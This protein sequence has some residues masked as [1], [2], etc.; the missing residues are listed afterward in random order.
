M[1]VCGLHFGFPPTDQPYFALTGA[2]LCY[3]G[4]QLNNFL[5]LLQISFSVL[6]QSEAF[7]V[8]Q[9]KKMPRTYTE[10]VEH[11]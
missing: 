6:N 10:L 5:L 2:V 1:N 7:I 9:L 4:C 8:K 3:D 11:H